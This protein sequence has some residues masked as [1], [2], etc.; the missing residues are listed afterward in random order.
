MR[1]P[2]NSSQNQFMRDVS[3][4]KLQQNQLNRQISTGQKVTKTSDNAVAAA[5]AAEATNEKSRIQAFANNIDRAN[6][7]GNFSVETL[8]SFKT[9]SD[10]ARK[11]SSI[12][13]GLSSEADLRSREADLRQLVEGGLNTLNTKLGNDYL[14]AGANIGEKPFE[15]LRYTEFLED[16]NGDFVDLSGNPLAPGEPPVPAVMRDINGDI[17]FDEI[18]SPTDNPIPEG[19]YV[20]PVTGNQTDSTGTPLPGPVSLDAGIDF[21]TGEL[22]A[23]DA[24]SGIWEPILDSQENPISPTDPDPSGTGFITT[25]RALP[26][27][28][29]G[30]VY[31]VVYTGSTDRSDDIRFRVAE[32]SQVDP[33]SRGAQNE[34]YGEILNNMIS[35]R[36]AFKTE[37]LDQ[38]TTRAENLNDSQDNVI[39][40]IVELAAKTNGLKTLDKINTA[41]FNEMEN[42][43][44]KAVDAD[45][46]ETIAELSRVQTAYEAALA[47]GAR[48]Q[49]LSILDFLR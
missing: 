29:V 26:S 49:S 15:A 2:F 19:T 1:V 40:G 9:I 4:L 12:N 28:Y 17:I 24:D 5:R 18:L 43:I 45:L 8:Q 25:T 10:S 48:I 33:F 6:T 3:A 11:L 21:N 27:D 37:D 31:Q 32:N 23:L 16:S 47:S 42:T 22:I 34:G 30:E 14:F 35:L 39:G 46:A 36:D 38:V 20:D 44:S 41:R 7:I 13:D